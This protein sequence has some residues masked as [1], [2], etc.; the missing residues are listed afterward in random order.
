[1]TVESEVSLTSV[2]GGRLP[3]FLARPETDTPGPT[4]VMIYEIFGMTPE[5]RRIAR[6]LAREGYTVLIPDLFSPAAG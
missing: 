6:E 4:I 2:N 5:M 3:G 1:M